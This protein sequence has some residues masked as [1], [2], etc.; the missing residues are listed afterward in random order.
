MTQAD[1]TPPTQAATLRK[2]EFLDQV[3]ANVTSNKR[4]AKAVVEAT[5]SALSV[6]LQ[7]GKTLA[8]A[9]FGKARVARVAGARGDETY[10]V[11][12][13]P[14]TG[15]EAAVQADPA[16]ASR[17]RSG[18]RN[19]TADKATGKSRGGKTASA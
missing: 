15:S 6:A 10:V 7:E 19:K 4:D 11:R 12:F 5:L 13:K 8:I 3:L 14:K 2:K 1:K 18:G 16:P 17:G 9:P